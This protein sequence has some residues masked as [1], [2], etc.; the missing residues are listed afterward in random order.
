[1]IGAAEL[2]AMKPGAVVVNIARGEVID[3]DA[4]IA[5]LKGDQTGIDAYSDRALSRIWKAMRF[6]WQMTMMLH[7]F[8]DED[9]FSAQMR[10]ATLAHLAESE[11][12]QRDLAENY[13]GLP[14]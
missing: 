12:A 7:R 11:T 1:M 5:A 13:V 4:L 6:S 8:D 10:R 14:Y 2:A 9:G 3:Q